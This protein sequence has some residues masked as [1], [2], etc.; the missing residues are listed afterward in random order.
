MFIYLSVDGHL[1]SFYLLAFMNNAATNICVQS[2]VWIQDVFFTF[3][4][5][6]FHYK[7]LWFFYFYCN[8]YHLCYCQG[9]T[10]FCCFYKTF[11]WSFMLTITFN[12]CVQLS[13]EFFQN[14]QINVILSCYFMWS[15]CVWIQSSIYSNLSSEHFLTH[16]HIC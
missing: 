16:K 9:K 7:L 6:K 3:G 13:P 14:S 4:V 15:C 11:S 5:L 1:D 12:C 10:P 2:F 8:L